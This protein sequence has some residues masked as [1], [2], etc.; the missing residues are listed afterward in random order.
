MEWL[1]RG[2][3][4]GKIAMPS[5]LHSKINAIYKLHFNNKSNY[6]P[7][8]IGYFRITVSLRFKTSHR[9]KP[10][11]CKWI[12][13]VWEWNCER[14]SFS[15]WMVHMKTRFDTE[16]TRKWPIGLYLWS[17]GAQTYRWRHKQLLVI[18]ID[19]IY[20]VV[21]LFSNRSQNICDTLCYPL[22]C[23]LFCSYH[24]WTSS[25]ISY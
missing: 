5:L 11:I 7:I 24:I 8:S 13:F 9:A 10:F 19:S 3:E 14:N 22:V 2:K 12:W 20:V 17:V 16:A 1:Y 21:S 15:I 25:V 4:S 18:W 6:S 23:H